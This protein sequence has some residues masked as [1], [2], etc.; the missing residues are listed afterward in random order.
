MIMVVN[1]AEKFHPAIIS[2]TFCDKMTNPIGYILTIFEFLL[3]L[4]I[5]PLNVHMM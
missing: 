5:L 2:I 3:E 4:F 1:F